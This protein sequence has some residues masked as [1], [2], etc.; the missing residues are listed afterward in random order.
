M[1][2][3]YVYLFLTCVY[4]SM[5]PTPI[6]TG[7]S[8]CEP[9]SMSCTLAPSFNSSTLPL[10]QGS[11]EPRSV[12]AFISDLLQAVTG[13]EPSLCTSCEEGASATSR[14]RDCSELLCDPC[15]RAH[16]RVRITKDH[17]ILRFADETPAGGSIC[18]SQSSQ[19][20]NYS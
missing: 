18:G 2:Y 16:Q 13:D 9:A 8:H 6:S 19:V 15:V 7:P 17:R 5:P 4:C 14:C 10:P 20:S 1:F 11:P 12:D 3:L